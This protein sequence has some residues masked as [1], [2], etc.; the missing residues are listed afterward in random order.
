MAK[1]MCSVK[2]YNRAHINRQS[3]KELGLSQEMIASKLIEVGFLP[4]NFFQL[5]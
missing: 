5:A 2:G 4:N 1:D 3:F